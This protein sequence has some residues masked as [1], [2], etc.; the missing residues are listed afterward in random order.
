MRVA[1]PVLV[2]AALVV[3]VAGALVVGGATSSADF[4]SFNPDWDGT[5]DLRSIADAEDAEPVVVRN[6]TSYDDYGRGDVAFVLAPESG[7]DDA[8][9][10]GVREFVERGGTLVVA[11]RD[12]QHGDAL[13]SSVGATARPVGPVLRDDRNYHRS[14]ALPVADDV[15]NHSL[16]ADVPSVTLNHGTALDPGDATVLVASSEF[17]YLDRDASGSRSGDEAVRSYPVA[18]VESVGDGRVVVVGDPSVFI[19]AMSDRAGNEA[20]ARSLVA[21]ADH[22]LVDVST[23]SVPPLVAA[24]LTVRGSPTL[25]ALLGLGGLVAVAASSRLLGRRRSDGPL[26]DDETPTSRGNRFEGGRSTAVDSRRSFGTTEGILRN[27]DEP[28]DDE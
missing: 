8:E 20:F 4:G 16:V 7:Y 5:S 17:S 1:V 6:A 26:G 12:G 13:L 2:A 28:G 15:A 11:E 25:Q 9:A 27:P 22:A 19:N 3:A 23:S 10:A 18:T 24:L 21:D 14:P